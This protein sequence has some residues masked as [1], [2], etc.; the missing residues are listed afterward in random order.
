M[1]GNRLLFF[2][3][4]R[5]SRPLLKDLVP[6]L[7]ANDVAALLP[8]KK[9]TNALTAVTSA[10]KDL[11]SRPV[12]ILLLSYPIRR[13]VE[14]LLPRLVELHPPL[15]E[16]LLRQRD[17][18][19]GRLVGAA[20]LLEPAGR[21]LGLHHGPPGRHA[22]VVVDPAPLDARVADVFGELVQFAGGL[23]EEDAE[24]GAGLLQV[25]LE[26]VDHVGRA[27]ELFQLDLEV[28]SRIM[29][30]HTGVRKNALNCVVTIRKL[31]AP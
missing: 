1:I 10:L 31:F 8:N 14:H 6:A 18:L 4:G 28:N 23:V 13:M 27:V 15:R 24:L 20:G 26:L 11:D 16:A 25:Q 9:V 17:H 29:R 3:T 7:R 21:G 19:L 30:G 2:S 22:G 5:K 12:P